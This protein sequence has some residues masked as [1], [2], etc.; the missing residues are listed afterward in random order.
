MSA[1]I[2]AGR[3]VICQQPMRP[4]RYGQAWPAIMPSRE[5][6]YKHLEMVSP[7][8][9]AGAVPS[10]VINPNAFILNALHVKFTLSQGHFCRFAESGRDGKLCV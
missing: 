4:D 5:T 9:L 2:I 8:F 1:N 7:A 10:L 3:H 6:V